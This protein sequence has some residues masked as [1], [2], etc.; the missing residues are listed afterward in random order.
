MPDSCSS[1]GE[2]IAPDETITSDAAVRLV[3]VHQFPR[4]SPAPFRT[5][6]RRTFAWVRTVRFFR[7]PIWRQIGHRRRRTPRIPLRELVVRHTIL[8]LAGYVL[9]ERNA[10]LGG[11]REIGL[12]DRQRCTRLRDAKRTTLAVVAVVVGIV[13]LGLPEIGEHILIA[14]ASATHLPPLVVVERV[15]SSVD[16]R[17]DSRAATDDLGLCVSEY[18]VLHVFLRSRCSSPSCRYLWSSSRN[19]RAGGRTGASPGHPPQAEGLWRRDFLTTVRQ[20]RCPPIRRR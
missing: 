12:T 7:P 4:Q 16:L 20:V 11:R 5:T 6:S 17:V 3:A 2:P 15:P 1:R 10:K 19:R 18:S 13:V 8:P 9:V 14:P